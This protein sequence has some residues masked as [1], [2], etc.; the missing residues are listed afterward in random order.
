MYCPDCGEENADS[1]KFCSNCGYSFKAAAIPMPKARPT[2]GAPYQPVQAPPG[3]YYPTNYPARPSKDRSIALI[4]EILLGLFGFLGFG[5]IYS[6]NVGTGIAVLIGM[7]VWDAMAIII[8]TLTVGFGL[9]CTIP[10]SIAF[11][12]LSAMM[13]NTYTKQHTELFGD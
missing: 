12:V 4:L 11:I 2:S 6:G 1:A 3:G 13:L 8:A 10:I 7:L 9:I 5:W